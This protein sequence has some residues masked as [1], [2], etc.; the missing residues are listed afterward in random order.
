LVTANRSGGV[1]VNLTMGRVNHQPFKVRFVNELFKDFVPNFIIAP[2]LEPLMDTA[3]LPVIIRQI[4][5]WS[6]CAKNPAYSIEK[7]AVIFRNSSPLSPLPRKMRLYFI[8][9]AI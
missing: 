1:R 8:P 6:A 5:P 7:S 9:N 2:P 3:K 4:A